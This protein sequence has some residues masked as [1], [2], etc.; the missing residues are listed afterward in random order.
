MED[1]RLHV[2][3]F[4]L[5]FGDEEAQLVNFADRLQSFRWSVRPPA[6]VMPEGALYWRLA[7]RQGLYNARSVLQEIAREI[8]YFGAAA[9]DIP[10]VGVDLKVNQLVGAT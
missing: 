4:D 10:D 9:G 8:G 3:Y 1:C 7:G 5:V 2:V 6:G